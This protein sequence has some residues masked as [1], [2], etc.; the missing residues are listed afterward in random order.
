M[1]VLPLLIVCSIQITFATSNVIETNYL[2]V[3]Y[4]VFCLINSTK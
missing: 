4:S 2:T 1:M 3:S